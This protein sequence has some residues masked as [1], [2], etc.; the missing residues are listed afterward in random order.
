[1]IDH[2]LTITLGHEL[3]IITFENFLRNLLN[4]I[5]RNSLAINTII[6]DGSKLEF[7][8]LGGLICFLSLCGAIK[9]ERLNKQLKDIKIYFKYP[10][11]KVMDH[12][13]WMQFFKVSNTYR[14]IENIE[15]LSQIDEKYYERWF[16]KLRRYRFEND[17]I[18][19]KHIR[20]KYFRSI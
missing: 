20:Q 5:K 3:N 18:K 9:E 2:E 10:S 17:P 12:L 19:K 14:F 16:N 8:K 4:E 7:I 1:M 13:H 6:F 15:S 11:G